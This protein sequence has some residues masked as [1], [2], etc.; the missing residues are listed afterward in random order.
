MPLTR[1]DGKAALKYVV[2][3]ISDLISIQED[4][5]EKYTSPDGNLSLSK[6][7]ISKCW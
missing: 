6:T 4:D 1:T 2:V 5:I 7:A 3:T